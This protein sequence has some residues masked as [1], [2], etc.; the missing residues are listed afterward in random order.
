[1]VTF[2]NGMTA[3]SAT[4]PTVARFHMGAGIYRFC[5]IGT[6]YGHLHT[7]GGDVRTWG[8]YSAARRAAKAYNPF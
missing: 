2:E 1:M 7:C 8:S 3:H 4:F 6:A 5:V